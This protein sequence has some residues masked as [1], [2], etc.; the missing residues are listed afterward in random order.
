MDKPLVRAEALQQ[1]LESQFK[2]SPEAVVAPVYPF[3]ARRQH[4]EGFVRLGFT[5]DARGRA[6]NIRVV[7]SAP[8]EIFEKSAIKALQKWV[9]NVDQGHN[10]SGRLYQLFEFKLEDDGPGLKNSSRRCGI[11][12]SRLCGLKRNNP[13]D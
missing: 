1:Q 10:D 9:F 12:G 5:V 6:R 4:L 11:T 7:D 8:T 3:R 13:K 2:I